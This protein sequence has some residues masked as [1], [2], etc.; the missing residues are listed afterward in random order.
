MDNTLIPF[1]HQIP[2]GIIYTNLAAVLR[3]FNC[4]ERIDNVKF[5]T[6]CKDTYELIIRTFPWVSITPTLHKVLD[7]SAQLIEEFNDGRG[8]KSLSEEGLETCHKYIRRY[9]EL[10]AE[11]Y[12]SK[13]TLKMSLFGSL[14][15]LIISHSPKESLS[16]AK[17]GTTV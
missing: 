1:E 17:K 7:H 15:N 4:D 9:R 10:L 14:L 5:A 3:I 8:L 13:L 11:K 2:P 12:L 6:L 16:R